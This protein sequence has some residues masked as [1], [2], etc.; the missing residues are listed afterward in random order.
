[1]HTKL[2]FA[3][4]F[5]A[6]MTTFSAFAQE[7]PPVEATA[8]TEVTAPPAPPTVTVHLEGDPVELQQQSGKREWTTLCQSPCDAPVF[9]G[10]LFRVDG[11]G[12]LRSKTFM[13]PATGPDRR[14]ILDVEGAS[15]GAHWAGV[16]LMAGGGAAMAVGG[17]L[18]LLTMVSGCGRDCNGM[19]IGGLVALG[20]G[21][22]TLTVGA[23][24]FFVT[25]RTVVHARNLG[26]LSF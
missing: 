9:A 25:G 10:G 23:I 12:I 21:A 2:G 8:P 17:G 14:A 11:P 3:V 1:M 18:A 6:I 16:G 26:E 19:A 22:L 5:A 15:A 24:L 13:L 4:G 7:A 20:A